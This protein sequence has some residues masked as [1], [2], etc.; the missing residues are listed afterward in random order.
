MDAVKS[1]AIDITGK[2]FGKLTV[3]KKH[4][5]KSKS[6]NIRWICQCD[7]GNTTV[8][9]GSHLRSNHTTSCGCNKLSKIANGHSAERIYRTW[10]KMH[11][12][13]ENP[14]HDRFKWYGAKGISVCKEWKDFMIFRNWAMAN[15]YNDSLTIDRINFKGNYCPENCRWVDMKFQANNRSNNRIIEIDQKKFTVSQ[16][17]IEYNLSQSTIFNRLKLGWDVYRIIHTPERNKK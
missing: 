15:G 7:C 4:P 2:R 9:I 16:L 6:G 11:E 17:S 3:L 5:E 10:K 1:T 14:K 12:R 8:V 13:C